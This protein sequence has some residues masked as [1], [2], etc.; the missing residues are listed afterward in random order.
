MFG[1]A[2]SYISYV[3]YAYATATQICFLPCYYISIFIPHKHLVLR[4]FAWIFMSCV[5][6][7]GQCRE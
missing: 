7:C 2:K 3:V 5:S 6:E 4:V 1:N